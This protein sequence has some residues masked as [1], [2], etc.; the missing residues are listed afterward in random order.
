[1]AYEGPD[2]RGRG[3]A[4]ADCLEMRLGQVYACHDCGLQLKVVGECKECGAETCGCETPCT[5]EC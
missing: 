5:L 1:M 3:G 2:Y 4:M